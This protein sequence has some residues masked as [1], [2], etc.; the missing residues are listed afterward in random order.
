M[1][2]SERERERERDQDRCV[3]CSTLLERSKFSVSRYLSKIMKSIRPIIEA[4]DIEAPN[5]GSRIVL[6]TR[7]ELNEI[8][9]LKNS[10]LLAYRISIVDIWDSSII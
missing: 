3:S 8:L 6:L 5:A 1:R 9:T 10:L 7:C 2:E 4:H